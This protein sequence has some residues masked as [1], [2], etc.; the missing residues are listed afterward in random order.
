MR[1]NSTTRM[2]GGAVL[3]L[4]LASCTVGSDP[5][6]RDVVP[7]PTARAG[8]QASDA[9]QLVVARVALAAATPTPMAESA[10]RRPQPTTR[11]LVVALGQ[12]AADAFGADL[13]R[14]YA[15]ARPDVACSFA[16]LTDR[17]LVESL[18]L[19]NADFGV[20]GGQ[21]SA[22][23]QH[24]G[25]RQTQLAVEVFALAVAAKSPVRS[26]SPSQVRQ[27]FTGQAQDWA[28][29]G[30]PAGT[31]VPVAPA[32]PRFAE[33]AARAMIPGDD[34][35]ASVTRVAN[36]R[37]VADQAVQHPGAIGVVRVTERALEQGL[38]LVQIDFTQPSAEAFTWNTYPFGLPVQ[39][40]TSGAPAGEAL[41]FLDFVRSDTGRSALSATL[42][43]R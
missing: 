27:I 36:E 2:R 37:Y 4:L 22:R 41:R 20:I 31:I 38:Q 29:F 32:E 9:P 12:N 26:L 13:R 7:A 33:R 17:D 1:D 23:E 40:I 6:P 19:G 5:D 35:A 10:A 34:F 43:V 11:P 25:L 14:A 16:Q 15:E 42:S 24:A 30:F 28:Q 3:G 39:L 18:I 21:L 8:D